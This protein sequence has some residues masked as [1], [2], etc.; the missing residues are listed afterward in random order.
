M[1]EQER[2]GLPAITPEE[3][4]LKESGAFEEA[5]AELMRGE[6]SKADAQVE[7]YVHDLK[8][9]LEPLGFTIVPLE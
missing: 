8:G 9:E 3:S 6:K 5:R 2:H 4:E 7:Q 1:Q